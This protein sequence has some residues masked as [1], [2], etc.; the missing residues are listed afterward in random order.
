MGFCSKLY[1]GCV[2]GCLLFS[3]VLSMPL[4]ALAQLSEATASADPSRAGDEILDT[5]D[6]PDVQPRVPV[7]NR[8]VLKAPEGADHI[9]L[10]L[11]S[12]IIEGV[13]V[14]EEHDIAP[15]YDSKIGTEVSLAELYATA[16]ALTRKYRNDGYILTQVIVPPQKIED[17]VVKLRV[18]EGFVDKIIIEGVEDESEKRQIWKY[19]DNLRTNGILDAKDLERYLLLIRDLPGVSARSIL[20]K[21]KTTP[22]ASDLTLIITRDRFEGE[23]SLDNYGSRFL[24]VYRANVRGEFN[25][26]FG[27]NE[28]II[29]QFSM[30]GDEERPDELLFGS[31]VY[32]QILSRFGSKLTIQGFYSDS[33]PGFTLQ[34][35]DVEGESLF[36]SIAVSHPMIRSRSVNLTGRLGFDWRNVKSEDD[37]T[38][39]PIEDRIRS[40]RVG[41]N[42]QFIDTLLG[43]RAGVNVVDFQFSQGVPIFGASSVGADNLT[44]ARGDSRHTKAELEL[45]RLQRIF[46]DI[47]ILMAARGQWA[48]TPLLSSE[49]FSIGGLR[50]GRGYDPSEIIADEGFATKVELQWNEPKRIKYLHDYQL[51]SFWDFGRVFDKDATISANDRESISSVGFGVRGEI[52][53]TLNLDLGIAYPLTRNVDTREDRDPRYYFSVSREL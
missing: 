34:P 33:E 16:D 48:S 28:R 23:I 30:A 1:F 22:G 24:G 35:F 12:L 40:V 52:T 7:Q 21:S 15:Y 27:F 14:Y 45:Q 9:K 18:V 26:P 50:Y 10:V 36:A 25:S 44:R 53:E 13:S 32:E 37:I 17:G 39:E 20:S 31:A 43:G 5:P 3:C 4:P 19:A 29:T 2:S 11:N 42:L 46:P 6:L 38:P 41:A 47:N 8:Q 49:E 51:F